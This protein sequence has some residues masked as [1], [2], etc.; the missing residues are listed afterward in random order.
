M[1]VWCWKPEQRRIQNL[2]GLYLRY[3]YLQ[4][5]HYQT[6]GLRQIPLF[7]LILEL[8]SKMVAPEIGQSQIVII[9][10]F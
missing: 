4:S 5:C 2:L 7:V 8:P 6:H 9:L 1:V 10:I 3:A